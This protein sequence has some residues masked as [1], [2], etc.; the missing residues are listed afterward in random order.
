MSSSS[1][2]Q[3]ASLESYIA[4]ADQEAQ[5]VAPKLSIVEYTSCHDGN[6]QHDGIT[7]GLVANAT[8][9]PNEQIMHVPAKSLID[10]HHLLEMDLA[11]LAHDG[12]SCSLTDGNN[13][14]NTDE[15]V[16]IIR[17]VR[18]FSETA[19]S[20]SNSS[21]WRD[22]TIALFL[23]ALRM[24]AERSEIISNDAAASTVDPDRDDDEDDSSSVRISTSNNARRMMA[25]STAI[26]STSAPS[27]I[28]DALP[29]V[30]ADAVVVSCDDDGETYSYGGVLSA[31]TAQVIDE[32]EL[33]PVQAASTIV[34]H[35]VDSNHG[36][37]YEGEFTPTTTTT[38]SSLPMDQQ[39]QLNRPNTNAVRRFPSFLSHVAMLPRK[40]STPLFFTK[41]ELERMCGTNCHGYT[42][43]IKQQM[44]QDWNRLKNGLR[45]YNDEVRER[46]GE[47][48]LEHEDFSLD[49]YR[50]A[51]SVIYTR[52]TDF[53]KQDENTGECVTTRVIVPFF[54]MINH[55]FE[56]EIYHAMYENGKSLRHSHGMYF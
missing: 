38:T 47:I 14:N 1:A 8:I 33:Q 28:D 36:F 56:S 23:I 27:R 6:N 30:H 39:Q 53:Q 3:S 4:W 48:V 52:S 35:A 17:F 49:L 46:D 37:N 13:N 29:V 45:M 54:D 25:A 11:E 51:L 9:Y 34:A 26:T 2:V 12:S 42:V 22:D 44:E 55:S 41:A 5:I 50:W 31:T 24:K 10:V 7:R 16:N 15:E 43:R 40:F 18:E 20:K 32:A 19:M 21:S